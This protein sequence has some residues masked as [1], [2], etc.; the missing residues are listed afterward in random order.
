MKGVPLL[1]LHGLEVTHRSEGV[2]VQ[3]LRG[4]DLEVHRG[5]TVALVGE[6]GSGKSTL[7]RAAVR[8]LRPTAGRVLLGGEDVTRL[9]ERRL[10]PLRPLA[11]LVFQDPQASLDPRMSVEEIVGEPFRVVRR[12]ACRRA[13]IANRVAALLE[14]V[15][16]SPA[17]AS[18]RP[19]E[20]SGGQ[21]QRV[22]LARALAV[23]PEILLLDEPLSSLDLPVQAQLV[24]LLVELQRERGMAYL[25]VT[26]DLRLARQLAHRVAVLYRGRLVEEGAAAAVLDAPS[27][28]YT[29]LLRAS[30][31]SLEPR[32]ALPPPAVEPAPEWP[33]AGCAFRPRCPIGVA[34]C[35]AT[36][37]PLVPLG[38]RRVACLLAG[39]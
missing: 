5:E 10:R 2:P 35:E 34:R 26:H 38:G 9:S 19:W 12:L 3:A 1:A 22:A 33:G 15:G 14:R 8:L 27:H 13:E 6:S 24:D 37:P 39:G 28:P 17:L 20:L 25:L 18:R 16:L 11:Q 29:R 21:R 36:E 23:E 7:A 32:G 4:V 30:I 31:P